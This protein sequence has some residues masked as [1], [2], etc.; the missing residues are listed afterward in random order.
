MKKLVFLIT[1]LLIASATTLS[2]KKLPTVAAKL[3]ANF[4]QEIIKKI[5]YPDFARHNMIEGEVWMKVTVDENQ[6]VK[7]VDVS[8][9]N[10]ELGE[11]VKKQL[12]NAKVENAKLN[13]QV[14]YLKVKFDLIKK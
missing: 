13:G 3:P 11:H 7:L 5:D 10:A 12:A 6:Q 4:K 8:S 1:G 14:Y 9:T 2:A